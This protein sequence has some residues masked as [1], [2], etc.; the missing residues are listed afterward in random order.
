MA[1]AH[2]AWRHRRV[3]VTGGTGLFALDLA[4]GLGLISQH[5]YVNA[6]VSLYIRAYWP[7]VAIAKDLGGRD[8]VVSGYGPP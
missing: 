5:F 8:R 4:I 2:E 6:E 7:D 3:F 1:H